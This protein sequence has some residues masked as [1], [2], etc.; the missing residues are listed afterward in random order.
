MEHKNTQQQIFDAAVELFHQKGYA[1]A[2]IREIARMVGIKESSIYNHYKNKEEIFDCIL[3]DFKK[4]IASNRPS[5]NELVN[6]IEAISPA[7]IIKLIFLKYVRNEDVKYDKIARIIFIEQYINRRAGDFFMK[8]MVE[9]PLEY[10]KKIF[11][12][13]EAADKIKDPDY[14]SLTEELHYGFL[15]LMLEQIHRKAEEQS[16]KEMLQ[17][18]VRHVDFVFEHVQII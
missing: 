1:G 8:Y 14:T 11:S 2:T 5:E 17:K 9:E 6:L 13:M 7:E 4:G 15:G 16:D 18:M 10:Y 12:M 3:N